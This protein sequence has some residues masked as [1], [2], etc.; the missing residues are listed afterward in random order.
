MTVALETRSLAIGYRRRKR[1]K[2]LARD[3]N[4]Q[5][6]R[7]EL[8]GLLGANGVGKS[9]LLRTLARMR[10]PL[11]GQVLLDGDEAG[12]LA[13]DEVARRLSIVL[14][15][16]PQVSL[17]N[18]YA[19]AALGRYPHSDWLGRLGAAD[20][21][22]VARALDAVGASDLAEQ[23]VSE[24]SDGQRQ[25]LMIARALAQDCPLMLLDEPTAYL[26]YPRRVETL[27]LLHRLTRGAGRAILVS[28]HELDLAL[29][30]CDKLWLMT[31][32]GDIITGAPQTLVENGSLSAAFGM[33]EMPQRRASP[34]DENQNDRR[35]GRSLSLWAVQDSNL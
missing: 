29:R 17:L 30:Y 4:L 22:Q 24:L 20:H 10:K 34:L 8:V 3:L 2:L 19:L 14:T 33:D 32:G 5:L 13:P 28:T 16:A 6:R 35:K 26:D 31:G 18:G 27:R 11:A 12:R 23:R 15:A 1:N 7:G 9:T 21:A 25:K